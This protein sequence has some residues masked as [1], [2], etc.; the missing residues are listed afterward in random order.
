MN[1]LFFF[2]DNDVKRRYNIVVQFNKIKNDERAS[3]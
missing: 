3:K 2:K 1:K